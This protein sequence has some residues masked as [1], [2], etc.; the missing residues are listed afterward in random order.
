MNRRD[1]SGLDPKHELGKFLWDWLK[2]KFFDKARDIAK[3]QPAL[4]PEEQTQQI[5]RDYGRESRDLKRRYVPG[6]A[7][8]K[9]EKKLLQEYICKLALARA[10]TDAGKLGDL[11]NAVSKLTPTEVIET[12]VTQEAKEAADRANDLRE[13][14]QEKANEVARKMFG[15]RQ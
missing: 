6:P 3:D 14:A 8:T 9:L 11:L 10:G 12:T 7:R 5:L 4:T 1:P 13:S 15:P 2:E